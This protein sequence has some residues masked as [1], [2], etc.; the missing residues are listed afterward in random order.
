MSDVPAKSDELKTLQREAAELQESRQRS[1]SA[2]TKEPEKSPQAG[3][4]KDT[5]KGAVDTRATVAPEGEN[6]DISDQLEMYLRELEETALERP[7]LAL[8]ATFSLG[9]IVGHLFT[10]R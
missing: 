2:E 10:R 6:Q 4:E 7:V 3:A 1:G 9:V 8:L 5:E